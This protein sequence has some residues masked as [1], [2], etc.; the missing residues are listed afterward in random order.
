MAA[1]FVANYHIKTGKA[2]KL[3]RIDT[4]HFEIWEHGHVQACM[5]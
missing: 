2:K 1:E 5:R 3:A 4:T